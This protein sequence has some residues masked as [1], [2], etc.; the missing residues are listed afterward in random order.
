MTFFTA[1]AGN[2]TFTGGIGID[3]VSYA[4]AS[5]TSASSGVTVSL[6]NSG[7]QNTSASGI[8][9]LINIESLIG[10]SYDDNLT[11]SI[12]NDTLDGGASTGL[13]LGNDT[14]NG[15]A[16]SDTV[17]Y[18]S[19]TSGVNVSLSIVG[20]LQD[21]G[22]AGFDQLSG[23]ENLTGSAFNDTLSGNGS[24]NVLSGGAGSDTVSYA[25]AA[26]GVSVA[27]STSAAQ[28]TLGAGIDTLTGFENLT[29][30]NFNDT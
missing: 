10:S 3:T 15:G 26:A 28:N 19:A 11:G 7:P 2:D 5:S 9:T 27:L 8:D 13:G 29:G 6:A 22:G 1:T 20:A 24:N 25:N 12:G 17:S 23:F 16:G 4:S 21:T 18:A 14:L 30:S